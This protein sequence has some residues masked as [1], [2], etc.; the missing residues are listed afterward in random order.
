MEFLLLQM[1]I[2]WCHQ[3]AVTHEFAH[4]HTHTHTHVT[5]G[6]GNLRITYKTYSEPWGHLKTRQGRDVSILQTHGFNI[7]KRAWHTNGNEKGA[8][9]HIKYA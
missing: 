5:N 8:Q 6:K 1:L 4:T 3:H 7:G 2:E 9:P